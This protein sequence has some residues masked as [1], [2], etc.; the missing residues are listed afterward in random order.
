M[1]R[2]DSYGTMPESSGRMPESRPTIGTRYPDT[3]T[4]DEF[5]RRL[6]EASRQAGFCAAECYIVGSHS[7]EMRAFQGQ[8]AHFES[9]RQ[10]GL[11]FRG[12]LDGRM[13]YAFSEWLDESAI[14]FLLREAAGNAAL[15]VLPETLF[16]GEA[17]QP[18]AAFD[19]QLDQLQPDELARQTLTLEQ[20]GLAVDPR[21][22]RMEYALAEYASSERRIINTLGLDVS[23]RSNLVLAFAMARAQAAASSKQGAALRQTRQLASLDAAGAGREAAAKALAMLGARTIPSGRQ[24]VVLDR[25]AAT[26]WLRT[27]LPVFFGDRIEQ[28]FSMLGARL[29]Q[30]IAAPVFSLEDRPV[31][32]GSLY[33]PPFDSEGTTTRPTILVEQGQL[34]AVLH[35]RRTAASA[36]VAPTGNGFRPSYQAPVQVAATNCLVRPGPATRQD[37]LRQLDH[38]LLITGLSGLHAGTNP[39]SGD[40]S[41]LAE[42]FWIENGQ[43]AWPVEQIT[44]AGNFYQVLQQ[45]VA[46]GQEP[47]FSMPTALGQVGCPDLLLERLSIAGA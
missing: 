33:M 18:T 12:L 3:P 29:G 27:F 5:A 25:E 13:G 43:V 6:L 47:W 20:A 41:L 36:G 26:D 14:D 37:L 19:P 16:A 15:A 32:P 31:T 46:I 45:V 24:A 22:V 17:W 21:V 7:L 44:V 11:S 2:S 8:I 23:H 10:R 35:N 28:G 39:I 4:A 42:G 9:S 30:A 40:F 34:R 38:G 1:N